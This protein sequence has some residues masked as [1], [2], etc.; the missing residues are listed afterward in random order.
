M[1]NFLR[2]C[3][4]KNGSKVEMKAVT[5]KIFVK[6]VTEKT[7][8]VKPTIKMY[9]KKSKYCCGGKFYVKSTN[10]MTVK[11]HIATSKNYPNNYSKDMYCSYI[12]RV[13]K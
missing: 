4:V 8:G 13:S 9:V 5:E 7:T 6:V 11:D 2:L 10:D 12:F 3:N 1:S